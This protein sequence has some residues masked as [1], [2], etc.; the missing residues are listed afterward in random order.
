M[1]SAWVVVLGIALMPAGT[2]AFGAAPA[3]SEH[4][5]AEFVRYAGRLVGAEPKAAP[6][7]VVTV[8]GTDARFV[9]GRGSLSEALAA[10]GKLTLPNDLGDEGFV[11]QSVDDEAGRYVV[12]AGGGPK[13]TLYGVYHYLERLCHVG[14]FW[15]GDQVP[16][17]ASLP[18]AGIRVI[19]RPRWPMRQYLMDCEYTS[20]WWDW[21]QWKAEVDWAARH[22]FNVLSSNFDFT[23][24]WRAVWKRF[25]VDVPPSSLSGPPFHPWAGWH[26]WAMRPPYPAAFQD[27][28]ADLAKR[29]TEYGRSLGMRM[30]PDFRGFI[31]QVPREFAHAYRG[32][33][34]FLEVGWVGFDPPGVFLHPD[35]PLYAQVAK[36]Y[37]EEYLKRFGT[38]HLWASQSYCEMRPGRDD[39][40]QTLAIEIAVARKNLE[41]IRSVDPQAVLFTNS[42]TFLDRRREDVLAYL[43]ALPAD[44]FQVWEMPSDLERRPA[45][46]TQYEYYGGKPWLVGFL[47]AYGGTTMLHGDLADLVR[48]AR[49]AATD[50]RATNC[51]GLCLQPEA[52]RHNPIVFDLLARLAWDPLAVDLAAFVDDYAVRRYGAAAAPGMVRCHRELAASVYGSPGVV[53]PLYMLRIT[54]ERLGGRE[55]YGV[56][57]ARRFLPHLQAALEIALAES[58]RA[59]NSALYQ[60]DLIDI[61]RQFLS[62]LFNLRMARMVAAYRSGDR[63]GFRRE[64]ASLRAILDSQER[65]LSASDEFCLSPILARARALPHAPDDIEERIRDILTVWAGKILDYAHRDYYELVRFYYRK[66]IEAFLAHAE[67]NLAA[68]RPIVDDRQLEPVYREIEQKFVKA[69]FVVAKGDRYAGTPVQAVRELV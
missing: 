18:T 5:V 45:M 35:D 42:W 26:N 11:I 21:D 7:G 62:D 59:A 64:A 15:E 69:P 54:A 20:Y 38:D 10:K 61:A 17:L 29:F 60:R 32:K 68:G 2:V 40:S 24:T 23:A 9:I 13:G 25:G 52:I 43:A 14:F 39:P 6:G 46:Y 44:A 22:R 65:L 36:A 49:E 57:Q 27:V 63:E 4:A 12:I 16:R 3:L 31:G 30:A 34:R 66:R 28:Q 48:R 41:A 50:P 19:E 51:R 58:D 47:Y 37:A 53:C 67:A 55:P 8:P 33:A 56:E 1:K